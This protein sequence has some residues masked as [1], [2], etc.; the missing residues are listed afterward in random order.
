M[1]NNTYLSG[2]NM[3]YVV[4]D[5]KTSILPLKNKVDF[6]KWTSSALNE[7]PGLE[8]MAIILKSVGSGNRENG[9]R[10]IVKFAPLYYYKAVSSVMTENLHD[11]LIKEVDSP[12]KELRLRAKDHKR[13]GLRDKNEFINAAE[14]ATFNWIEGSIELKDVYERL[15]QHR[16]SEYIN[17]VDDN[18]TILRQ[19]QLNHDMLLR[20]RSINQYLMMI[21]IYVAILILIGYM[22]HLGYDFQVVMVLLL[23]VFILFFITTIKIYLTQQ[24]RHA[25]NYNRIDLKGY[26]VMNEEIQKKY[27]G[28]CT[29]NDKQV[30]KCSGL[31]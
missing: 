11:S 14:N 13:R 8:N 23:V 1:A 9:W 29:T 5:D 25:L 15:N 19:S 18:S 20:R 26:P 7:Q 31:A 17:L 16:N 3:E 24:R 27:I 10:R 21:S 28:D 12:L 4:S 22:N 2:T 30:G 6:Q